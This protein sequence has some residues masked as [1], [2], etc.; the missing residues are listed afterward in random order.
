M[1]LYSDDE[2]S[3]DEENIPLQNRNHAH[4]P[5]KVEVIKVEVQP[6]DTL[7]ALALK[8]GCTVSIIMFINLNYYSFNFL[9]NSCLIYKQKC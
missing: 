5:R 3:E 2:Y 9:L 4:A 6:E 1:L 7:Q 8:Y